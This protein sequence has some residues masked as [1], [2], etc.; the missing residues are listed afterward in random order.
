ME[1]KDYLKKM[2]EIHLNQ[3]EVYQKA[4]MQLVDQEQYVE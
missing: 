4:Y 2:A 1:E 3:Y